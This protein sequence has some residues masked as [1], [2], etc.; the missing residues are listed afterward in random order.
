MVVDIQTTD[1]N[2]FVDIHFQADSTMVVPAG[3]GSE[4]L[5]VL[6]ILHSMV[7]ASVAVALDLGGIHALGRW[8]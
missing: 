2:Y 3:V 5:V 6:D 4:S 7:A 8:W 1:Q